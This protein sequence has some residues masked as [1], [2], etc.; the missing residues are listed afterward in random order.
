MPGIRLVDSNKKLQNDHT[1]I[2]FEIYKVVIA[3]E[4]KTVVQSLRTLMLG[5]QS[6][7]YDNV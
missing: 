4:F 5:V 2:T 7:L 6:I 3:L 1:I